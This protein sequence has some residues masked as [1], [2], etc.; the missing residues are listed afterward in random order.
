MK[1][2]SLTVAAR[3]AACLAFSV[4]GLRAAIDGTV[5]NSTTGK[6]EAGVAVSLLHPG[7]G[8][9]QVLGSTKSG[10]DGTFRIDQDVPSPPALVQAIYK[11]S[12]YNLII[13]P[14]APST[15]LKLN[16]YE[17][18]NDAAA[19]KLAM[20]MVI[21][22]PGAD[23]LRVTERFELE[24]PTQSTYEDSAKGSLQFY[25][26]QGAD[27]GTSVTVQAPDGMP[28]QRPAEKTGKAGEFK[29]NYPLKPGKT[30]FDVRY[31]LNA[32]E[33]FTSKRAR[34][35]FPTRLVT[36]GGVTLSGDELASLG[37]EPQTQAHIYEVTAPSYEVKITGTGAF[38]QDDDGG[39][40]EDS[41]Q[42]KVEEVNARVYS[43]LYW[44]LGLTLGILGL[45]GVLLYRRGEA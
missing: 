24:N 44:V 14:G 42:P 19:N 26:P 32:S 2:R 1:Y 13:P 28:I 36:P 8:G 12:T 5:I 7:A 15:G 35:D 40:Q 34:T 33:T 10:P 16:V 4:P 30:G 38:R 21:L 11:G 23:K 22:E 25:L 29:V 43:R 17:A 27:G 45:G 31:S 18:T 39:A 20:H 37:Q 3:F 9:M 41:G 6:P